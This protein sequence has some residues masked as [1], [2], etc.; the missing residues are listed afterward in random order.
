MSDGKDIAV[1]KALVQHIQL[2]GK[3][4]QV[5]DAA[6]EAALR[7][8]DVAMRHLENCLCPVFCPK[9]FVYRVI[10]LTHLYLR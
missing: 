2:A 6:F 9:K 8:N 4:I 5:W 7:E 1:Y 10:F 3:L